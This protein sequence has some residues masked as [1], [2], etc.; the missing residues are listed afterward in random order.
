MVG[1]RLTPLD[2]AGHGD[3]QRCSGGFRGSG[4][5]GLR[6]CEMRSGRFCGG[7]GLRRGWQACGSRGH[8]IAAGA[9][10]SKRLIVSRDNRSHRRF[11]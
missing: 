1:H 4:R 9:V 10:Y 11:W 6:A 3:A 5:A 2:F 8:W 7:G